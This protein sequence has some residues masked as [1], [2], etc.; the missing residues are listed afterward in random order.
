MIAIEC[1][2]NAM[3]AAMLCEPALQVVFLQ[4]HRLTIIDKS[5]S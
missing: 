2:S 1:I 3:P 5:N 4:Q